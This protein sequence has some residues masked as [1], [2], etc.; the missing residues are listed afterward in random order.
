MP[1]YA[2]YCDSWLAIAETKAFARWVARKLPNCD[3]YIGISGSGLCAGRVAQSRGAGYIMDRGSTHARHAAQVLEEEHLRWK[4]PWRP[5]SPWLIENEEKEALEA[6]LITVPSHFV[7]KTFIECGVDQK[8]VRVV[9]YGVA[10]HEFYRV[11][12]PPSDVFRLLFVGQFSVRKGAPY[13]LNAFRAFRH[14]RKELIVVGI[15]TAEM[16]PMITA[17][18]DLNITFVGPVPRSRV[19][20]FM[21]SAHALVLPSIEEGL[22]LVQAQAMACGCP[23]IATPNTGSETLFRNGR[24]GLIVEARNESMLTEAFARMS[25]EPKLR[26]TMSVAS[27]ARVQAFGGWTKYANDIVAVAAE[28]KQ[29]AGNRYSRVGGQANDIGA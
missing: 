12:R 10:L 3:T 25:D 16:K 22:A 27:M 15:V 1:G 20:E 26:E 9:P 2:K 24:E 29:I 18:R 7:K 14:P 8:K 6:N 13:L 19:K 23:V 4:L 28:A 17:V 11:G 21:S 5:T